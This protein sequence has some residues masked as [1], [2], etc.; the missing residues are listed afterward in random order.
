MLLN[1]GHD[2]VL[3]EILFKSSLIRVSETGALGL[4][5]DI[6][7]GCHEFFNGT[8]HPAG[9]RGDAIPLAARLVSV[10]Y[11]YVDLTSDSPQRPALST[12]S[13][14]TVIQQGSGKQFDPRVVDAFIDVVAHG[15]GI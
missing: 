6:V 12:I 2:D 1:L 8:G 3:G 10:A 14:Q 7:S 4:A 11:A 13:A 15:F 9:L 5:R